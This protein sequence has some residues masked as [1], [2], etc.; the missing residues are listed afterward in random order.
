MSRGVECLGNIFFLSAISNITVRSKE[1]RCRS[2]PSL[3]I[4]VFAFV[5]APSATLRQSPICLFFFLVANFYGLTPM[6]CY[7]WD[8]FQ[9]RSKVH[10]H[11]QHRAN[12][13]QV[14]FTFRSLAKALFTRHAIQ[15]SLNSKWISCL[16]GSTYVTSGVPIC[17][18]LGKCEMCLFR[19]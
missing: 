17:L 5:V 4:C 14:M 3:F 19:M 8:L 10:I 1:V 18:R 11:D 12:S 13:F 9:F 6:L 2:G 15:A 7:K 16:F